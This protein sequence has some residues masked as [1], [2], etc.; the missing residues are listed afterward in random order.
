MEPMVMKSS[1]E[2]M[3]PPDVLTLSRQSVLALQKSRGQT[4]CFQTEERYFCQR[5][6]CE[7]RGQCRGLLAAWR[8]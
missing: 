1:T 4:P 7:W 6:D 3:V 2:D 8:R 5:N